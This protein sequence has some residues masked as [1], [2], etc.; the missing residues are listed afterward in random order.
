MMGDSESASM[1][2]FIQLIQI[3]LVDLRN[4]GMNFTTEKTRIDY[5][6]EIFIAYYWHGHTDYS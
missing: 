5:A 1:N 6:K 4:V 2:S 3:K